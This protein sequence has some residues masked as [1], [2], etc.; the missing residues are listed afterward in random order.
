MRSRLE[1]LASQPENL[2]SGALSRRPWRKRR[3]ASPKT[4]REVKNDLTR[5]NTSQQSGG[6]HTHSSN[7]HHNQG[8]QKPKVQK[9]TRPTSPEGR[10]RPQRGDTGVFA[11]RET[12]TDRP[13][14]SKVMW[15]F[16]TGE[17][18]VELTEGFAL[19][20]NHSTSAV[21]RRNVL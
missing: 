14:Q 7:H 16:Y 21:H 6:P 4:L 12:H 2:T 15:D 8:Q 11:V 9:K 17:G 18:N 19:G 13:T 20:L 1:E 5:S 10:G 3:S